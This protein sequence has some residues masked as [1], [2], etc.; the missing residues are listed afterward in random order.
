MRYVLYTV[1]FI[2]FINYSYFFITNPI[3]IKG[4]FYIFLKQ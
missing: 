3:S 4:S 2:P 1:P